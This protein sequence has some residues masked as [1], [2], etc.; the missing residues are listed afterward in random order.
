MGIT[1][2]IYFLEFAFD[3]YLYLFCIGWIWVSGGQLH[4][5]GL[6]RASQRKAG[7]KKRMSSTDPMILPL[8]S[9]CLHSDMLITQYN[10]ASDFLIGAHLLKLVD[11]YLHEMST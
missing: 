4:A 6:H 3:V 10:Y 9:H 8:P 7:E 2:A 1:A 5:Q 11:L